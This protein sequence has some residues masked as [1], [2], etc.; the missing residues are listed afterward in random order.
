MKRFILAIENL[1]IAFDNFINMYAY[2]LSIG[3][4]LFMF[5]FAFLWGIYMP[6]A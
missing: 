6:L 3:L 5:L 1:K 4:F 2:Q